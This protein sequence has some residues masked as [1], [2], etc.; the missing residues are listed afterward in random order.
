MF[1][2]DLPEDP[3]SFFQPGAEAAALRFARF[4]PP[5]LERTAEGMTLS[6]PHIR[7][8]RA[9]EFLIGDQLT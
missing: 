2:G 9:L 7:L 8:D 4:R 1:P 3:E 5:K 6:L